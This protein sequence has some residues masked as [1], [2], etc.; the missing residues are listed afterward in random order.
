[1]AFIPVSPPALA[2]PFAANG[3]K[4]TIPA[5]QNVFGRASLADGFPVETQVP[6]NAGGIPPS[7]LDVNGALYPLYMY[8]LWQQSGGMTSFSPL[9]NYTPPCSVWHNDK[10]YVCRAGKEL[11]SGP[12]IA[13]VGV[14]TPGET[15]SENYWLD[16]AASITPPAEKY[17]IGQYSWFEDDMPRPGLFSCLGGV[18]QNFSTKYPHAAAYFETPY[19]QKRLVTQA[20]Y[21]AL[22]VA[23]WHTCAD[24][25]KIGWNGIGG[26]NKFV[27][28][29]AADTLRLPDLAGMTPEQVGYDPLGVGGVHEDRVMSHRHGI[30]FIEGKTLAG[31][32]NMNRVLLS[33]SREYLSSDAV[34][35]GSTVFIGAPR[36]QV[37]AWISDARVYLGQPLSL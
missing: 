11:P 5:Q 4:A 12:D 9:L 3:D 23:T 14:K 26:V 13:G 19:G 33:D 20:Q 6:L 24:G 22:H 34:G 27:W 21:D 15:G 35:I 36:T 2:L 29:K 10:L 31:G 1:M 32:S 7:R 8:A 16:Y 37:R 25:T 28:D 30:G 17:D 18:V